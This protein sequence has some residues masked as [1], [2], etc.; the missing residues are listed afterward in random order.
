MSDLL[1]KDGEVIDANTVRFER[2]L[3]G[4]IERVWAYLT[5]SEKRRKWLASGDFDLREGGKTKLF[6]RH[7]ELSPKQSPAPERY[8]KYDE[9]G[10]GFD[11][12]VLRC[13]PPRLLTITWGG[14]PKH[15]SEVTFELT[16]QSGGDVLLTLTHR[17]LVDAA[18]MLSVSGGWHTHLG[19]LI[20]HL[21]GRTPENFWIS[22]GR[23]EAHYKNKFEAARR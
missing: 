5:E 22:H 19:V 1:Q 4:P 16:P 10:G 21:N 23:L 20:D 8:R 12:R 13:E 15:E 7:V 3:P 17:R 9:E 14:D 18:E 2:L 6:F 11:G